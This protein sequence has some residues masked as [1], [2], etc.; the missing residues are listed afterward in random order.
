MVT[1]ITGFPGSGKSYYEIDKIYNIMSKNH[2]LSKNIEV[3]YTNINGIKLD[4][5]PQNGIELKK[6][7]IDEFYKYLEQSFSLYDLYKNSDNVDEHLIKHSKEKGYFNC[8]IVFDECHDFLSNQDRVKIYWLTYHRHLHHEIDLLTQNKGL[9]NSKYRAIPEIFIEAQPRSKK[10]FSNTLTYKHYASFAMRK[11]DLFN[12][13][14]IKTRKEV[15]DLYTSGNTSKQKSIVKKFILIVFIGLLIAGVLFYNLLLSFNFFENTD[16]KED[17]LNIETQKL[18]KISNIPTNQNFQRVQNNTDIKNFDKYVLKV[19]FDSRE[20]YFIFNN[21]YS[22]IHFRKFLKETN[23]KVL[24]KYSLIANKKYKLSHLYIS[25]NDESLKK[26]FV[27]P[28]IKKNQKNL[29]DIKIN[30]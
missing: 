5:F 26:F 22:V 17:T 18:E 9:I 25:T 7:N 10:L 4:K 8:L 3:I 23:S 29:D 24:S 1:F 14:S 15:F 28:K 16:K 2:D 6:L 19:V 27:L 12:K 13:S 20:G 21:Y 30:F 11:N